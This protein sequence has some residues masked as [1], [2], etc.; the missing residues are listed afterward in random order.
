M[1]KTYVVIYGGSTGI[2]S[3]PLN[4]AFEQKSAE[5]IQGFAKQIG[6]D[7]RSVNN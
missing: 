2:L 7:Y 3:T 1:V 6:A 4:V 5:F